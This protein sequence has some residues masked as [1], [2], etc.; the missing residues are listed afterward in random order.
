MLS[1]QTEIIN[2]GGSDLYTNAIVV[3]R[4]ELFI[5]VDQHT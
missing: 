1:N 3:L 2:Q 5:S 4:W